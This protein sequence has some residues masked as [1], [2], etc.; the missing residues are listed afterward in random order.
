MT[1]AV[2]FIPATARMGE[3]GKL[4]IVNVH[5]VFNSRRQR[6]RLLMKFEFGAMFFLASFLEKVQSE[7]VHF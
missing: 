6:G 1:V 4:N 3:K 2:L 5:D 7:K